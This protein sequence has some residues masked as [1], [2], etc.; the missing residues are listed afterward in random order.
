MKK[1]LKIAG[2]VV[3]LLL[4]LLLLLLIVLQSPKAQTMAARKIVGMLDGVIDGDISIGKVHIRPF[5][6]VV[7][8]DVALVDRAPYAA[9]GE[10]PLDTFARARYIT[11]RIRPATLLRQGVIDLTE[12]YV[13]DGYFVLA[14]EPDGQGNL[15]RIFRQGQKPPKEP[16]E[17]DDKEILR[18]GRVEINGF[19]FRL[20]NYNSTR[21]VPAD[22][23]DWAD[24]DVSD[25]HLKGRK[26]RMHGK[27]VEG[28]AD[29]LSFREK[30]GMTIHKMSGEARVGDG[31]TQIKN[32]VIRDL[33][34]DLRFKELKMTYDGMSAFSHFIEEVKLDGTILRGSRLN[35]ETVGYFAPTLRRM[36]LV[37]NLE[38]E[39]HGYINDLH[40]NRFQF[41]TLDS[42]VSARV[43]GSLVGLPDSQ[44]ML[45]NY[46]IQDMSFTLGNLEKFI[47]GWAP[48]V[49]LGLDKYAPGE[50]FTFN[51]TATGPI[52][53][54]AVNGDFTSGAGSFNTV[55]DLR[56]V[57]DPKRPILIGGNLRTRDLDVG[58]IAGIDAV[59]P[60]TLYTTVQATLAGKSPTVKIDSLYIDRLHALGYD[61]T[62][63]AAT[64][65]YSENAFDGRIIGSDPNLNFIFQGIFSLSPKTKNAVYKFYANLGYAD[66]N[67]LNIDKRGTSRLSL[68]TSANFNRVDGNDLIGNIDIMDV[69]LTDMNG[70]HDIGDI[71]IA[72]HINDD[73]NRIR[74]QSRF[75][76]G[77]FVGTGFIND[78]IR[79]IQDITVRRELP[80][81]FRQ[82]PGEWAGKTY[83][84]HF[85]THDT[86]AILDFLK[87]G[88]YVADS[89]DIRLRIDAEG[90]LNGTV[91][92]RRIALDDKYVKDMVLTLDNDGALNGILT[93]SELNISPVL[94][95]SN[96]LILLAE[97]DH[98]GLGFS[99]DNDTELANKGEILL[100]GQ[101]SR[102]PSDSLLIRAEVLP[103][104]LY[105]NGDSWSIKRS[106]VGLYGQDI[107]IGD[108]TLDNGLQRLRINGGYSPTHADT[109][110]VDLDNFDL[111]AVNPLIGGNLSLQGRATGDVWIAS[112]LKE[113]LAILASLV[114][115]NASI[116]G[117]PLGTLEV[118]SDW[119][120]E[121][122][123]FDVRIQ[124]LLDGRSNLHAE[125]FIP[126]S[127]K[128]AEGWLDL[129]RLD[130]TY[131]E[132]ILSSV[133]S[134]LDGY[135][136]GGIDFSGPLN[137]LDLKSRSLRFED[138]MLRVAYTDVP[139]YANG[140]VTLSSSG[141]VFDDV[142]LR[143]RFGAQGRLRGSI[144]WDHFKDMS[145]NL[146]I[147]INEMEALHL[148]ESAG[149]AFYGNIF[150][151]GRVS[152]TGPL[153]AILLDVDADTAKEGEFH[154]PLDGASNANTS[155]LLTFKEPDRFIYIDPYDLMRNNVEAKRKQGN[156]LTVRI[157]VRPHP[158]VTAFIEVDKE[159][160]NT[161]SGH[162]NGN[163][164]VVVRPS[165]S[166]FTINGNYTLTD[167]VYHFSALNIA[168]RDFTIQDGSSI[169]FGGDIMESDLDIQALYRTKA[170]IG[171]LIA[172]TTSVNTRRN[173]ECGI[174]ITEKL[175]NPRITF[176]IEVPDL[177]PTTQARVQD[178]LN[179]EDKVQKQFLSLLISGG[180]LPD[181]TSGIVN[182]S[183]MLNSTVMEIMASQLSN[184]LQKLDIPIDLG[185]DYQQSATGNDIFDVAVSTELF[186][187]RVIVN[188][189][190]GNRQY[191]TGS[192]NQEVVGD[193]DI[194]IKLDKTGAFR[195]KLFSHSADQ[196]TNYLDNLQRN[197]VG[198]TYQQ[199]YNNFGEFLKYLFTP[200][201]RRTVEAVEPE[202]NRIRIEA[203]EEEPEVTEE[204]PETD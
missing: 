70:H 183:S 155:D 158:S 60:V 144:N 202:K 71:S 186:N 67:A 43:D 9:E 197:G 138:A 151:T 105:L 15:K 83:D 35:L 40:V 162:G 33:Y 90:S 49:K 52:N 112:P 65:S 47:R 87:P 165:T 109:L 88:I 141:L 156:E 164:D 34:S 50:T 129:D 134:R 53:R 6:A 38:G 199:E 12:A 63:I 54:L 154:V 18:V 123:G 24:L 77:T 28:I 139:Y 163:I 59:G 146:G 192:A 114:V 82:E 150:G 29:E 115:E 131:A 79:D 128:T 11:V 30:S 157:H 85:Q 167:G 104:A 44:N 81:L 170:S 46:K 62:G 45:L 147:D 149:Q 78:F 41:N 177:D 84:L 174:G 189:V 42:G 58:R 98:V 51:G 31:L 181:E 8:K 86:Q 48:N 26:L 172:D 19:R 124:N 61:Y 159:S 143:D 75:A 89:T 179:S 194:E 173:V 69:Q 106:D 204:Q 125:A 135:L 118:G 13:E 176:S 95:K 17:P 188:G 66:L 153:N 56:N 72:S 200:K 190:I 168:K 74:L 119:N 37:S 184:I 171:T 196:Y 39:V 32:L 1:I 5:D 166:L 99:Y 161:L 126:S 116:A 145:L 175:R 100:S 93:G 73:V 198:L 36:S 130:L 2:Y 201:K 80:S 160:G 193:L 103:S 140:P 178:A 113:R 27:V 7:L 191:R 169:K 180:F 4:V 96:R 64:G 21:E 107:R 55:L 122:G 10:A 127:F 195:L 101:L 23:I 187:N 76:E 94:A 68:R 182:N 3:G 111:N 20:R 102:S 120:D 152:I 22:A 133:F 16:K 203:P 132:P 185:L 97:D 108:L 110:R 92:S 142:T 14:N 148:S 121:R 117:E 57:T 137:A 25:I 136:S 91:R